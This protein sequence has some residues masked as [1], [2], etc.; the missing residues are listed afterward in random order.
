MTSQ[1][2]MNR[3]EKQ[4]RFPAMLAATLV[5]LCVVATSPCVLRAQD[6]EKV[7]AGLWTWK[8]S[9][10]VDCHGPFADGDREDDDFPI[11]A[12]LRTT[13]I[14]AAA[15][16]M[17]IRCGRA[18]TGMPSFDEGAYTVRPCYGRPLGP[19]PDNLQPTSRMLSS[20]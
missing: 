16:E 1:Q 5:L 12:N 6:N 9:G 19:A 13:R 3:D 11:G 17:T 20:D 10:C 15:F 18:G 8:T 14:D 7:S 2:P 4:M